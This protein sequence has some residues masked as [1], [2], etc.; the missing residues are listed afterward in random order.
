[1][2]TFLITAL[3]AVF[4]FGLLITSHELG[5]FMA[6]K[7]SGITVE[8]FAIGMGPKLISFKKGR[9]L[10]SLRLLPVGGYNKLLGEQ[11]ATD[12]PTAFSNKGPW[13]RLFVIISGAAMNFIIAIIIYSLVSFNLGVAKPIVG[14]LQPGYPAAA[15]GLMVND[16]L[17]AVNGENIKSWQDF[18]EKVS[19]NTGKS[20]T[21][22]VERNNADI[23]INITPVFDKAQKRYMIGI[24]SKLEKGNLPESV[25]DGI[26]G[27]GDAVKQIL[28]F[29]GKLI[30]GKV[31]SNDVGGPVAIVKMSGQVAIQGIWY[32]LSFT[33]FLSVNL[34]IMNLIPFPALDGGWVI[35]LLIEGITGKKI[36]ENKLGII[37][38][39]GFSLLIGL[40]LIVT[41]NDVIHLKIF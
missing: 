11:E 14:G 40:M 27:T 9:T 36:N 15:S 33:A 26:Y 7:L 6:A 17:V 22:K 18:T 23:D 25:K 21:L 34:G 12:D 29:L 39:V 30:R 5:H 35:L 37:N 8:E 4:V 28:P 38:L 13:K 24:S 20:M 10:Y 31:S 19:S 3:A 2:N 41:F 1:M 16:K 32:L